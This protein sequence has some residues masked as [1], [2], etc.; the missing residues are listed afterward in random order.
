M[1]KWLF[2]GA[3]LLGVLAAVG[4]IGLFF[5]LNSV[6]KSGV[7]TAGPKLTQ[8]PLRLAGVQLSPFSGSGSLTELFIGNPAGFKTESAIKVGKVAVVLRP[9]SVFSDTVLIESID[10]Q[11]PEIT[12][13]GTLTGSNLSKILENIEAAVGTEGESTTRVRVNDLRVTGGLINVS[14]TLLGGRS[15][16]VPLPDL[17][18]QGIGTG[19]SGVSTGELARQIMKPLLGSVVQAVTS[20]VGNLGDA[21]KNLGKEGVEQLNKTTEGIRSLFKKRE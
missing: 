14:M 10:I 7:E 2:R 20:A 17:H 9:S 6:V 4:V 5:S 21:A 8:T 19:G 12:F 15:L 3:I 1:K 11:A 16:S 18:L 13:E